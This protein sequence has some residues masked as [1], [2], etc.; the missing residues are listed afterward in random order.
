MKKKEIKAMTVEELVVKYKEIKPLSDN[1]LDDVMHIYNELE[2][3]GYKGLSEWDGHID[4]EDV[5]SMTNEEL[6]EKYNKD[7]AES[8]EVLIDPEPT[9]QNE[10]QWYADEM[11]VVA[12]ELETRGVEVKNKWWE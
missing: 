12:N 6:L 10:L 8:C 7:D 4:E 1:L 5:K 2:K 9:W 11:K 3:R